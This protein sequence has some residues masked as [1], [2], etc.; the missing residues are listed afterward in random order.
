MLN[1]LYDIMKL[2]NIVLY[3]T[4][5]MLGSCEISAPGEALVLL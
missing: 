4:I 2:S 3:V 1:F 5:I